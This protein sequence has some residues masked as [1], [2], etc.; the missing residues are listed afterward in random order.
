ME[1][2]A[3]FYDTFFRDS[4]TRSKNGL[5]DSIYKQNKSI[6]VFEPGFLR[7]IAVALLLVHC[8]LRTNVIRSNVAKPLPLFPTPPPFS[9]KWS[10]DGSGREKDL[11]K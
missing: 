3:P 6:P 10:Q 9:Q 11:L 8:V 2:Y 4:P 7:Q 1:E 5:I